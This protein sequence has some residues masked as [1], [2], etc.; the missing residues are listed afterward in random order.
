MSGPEELGLQDL[1]IQD[2][3][4]IPKR[5]HQEYHD[6]LKDLSP[7]A[8]EALAVFELGVAKEANG[9]MRDAIEYYRKAMNVSP[10]FFSLPRF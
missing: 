7:K 3:V 2:E 1:S 5:H 10:S 9:S 4:E 8:K 6:Q